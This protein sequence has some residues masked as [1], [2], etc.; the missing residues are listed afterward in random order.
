[1]KLNTRF[2]TVT[3]II[4]LAALSRLI[5]HLP[6]FT[7]VS[8]AALFGAAYYNKKYTALL[9]PIAILFITDAIIGFYPGMGW[10]YASFI[11]VAI[12][13]LFMLQKMSVTRVI[14]ASLL[15]SVSFYLFTNF[16]VWMAGTMYPHT[17]AGLVDCYIA[18]I[19]FSRYEVLGTLFYSAVM[20]G[21]YYL[22][23]RRFPVLVKS[24]A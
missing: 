9:V 11:M 20:F 13:G 12:I 21:G 6:N 5:P 14:G 1:M 4:I 24:R 19:P 10:V 3:G 23:Q 15:A 7:A 22:A 16:G 17:A 18:A 8:A 2:L